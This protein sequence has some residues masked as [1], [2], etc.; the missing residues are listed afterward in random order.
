VNRAARLAAGVAVADLATKAIVFTA[1]EEGVRTGPLLP[2]R[3]H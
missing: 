2:L 1:A 3:N